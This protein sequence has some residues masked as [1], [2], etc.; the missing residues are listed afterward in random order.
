MDPNERRRMFE[1]PAETRKNVRKQF[2][3][4]KIGTIE[5]NESLKKV[6]NPSPSRKKNQQRIFKSISLTLS[7]PSGKRS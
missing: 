1:K 2:L 3:E 5:S 6:S 4:D 7:C